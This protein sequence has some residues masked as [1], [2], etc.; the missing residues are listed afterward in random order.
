M[1]S[2]LNGNKPKEM[3]PKNWN[4][5]RWQIVAL[6]VLADRR[7][8]VSGVRPLART[9]RAQVPRHTPQFGTG[10]GR[11]LAARGG[12]GYPAVAD[13]TLRA[14][15]S[16]CAGHARAVGG[17]PTCR[18]WK[19]MARDADQHGRDPRSVSA[20]P[21]PTGL[22]VLESVTA[23]SAD[24]MVVGSAMATPPGSSGGMVTSGR[25]SGH[26]TSTRMNQGPPLLQLPRRP[27]YWI[28]GSYISLNNY[29]Y[30]T[31]TEHLCPAGLN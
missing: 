18:P 31:L 7:L 17:D 15:T 1:G 4:G 2:A 6:K 9:V 14:I 25:C 23:V 24:D 26:R 30:H 21:R 3:P 12:R 10:P 19:A 11:T 16:A 20:Q 27:A 22:D 28:V 13:D 29:S 8:L 5:T